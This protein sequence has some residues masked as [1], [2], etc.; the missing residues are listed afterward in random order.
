[1]VLLFSFARLDNVT[2]FDIL[3][4][5]NFEQNDV[6]LPYA[7]PPVAEGGGQIFRSEKESCNLTLIQITNRH[8]QHL[9]QSALIA[10]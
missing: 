4:S 9:L 7:V 3:T 2:T 1:M 8:T 5:S 6:E 10:Q